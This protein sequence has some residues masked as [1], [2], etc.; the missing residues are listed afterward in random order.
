MYVPS[1]VI[2]MVWYIPLTNNVVEISEYVLLTYAMFS[3]LDCY[4]GGEDDDA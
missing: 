1:M 4:G 2:P 3:I